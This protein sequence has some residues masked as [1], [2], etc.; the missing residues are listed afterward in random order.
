MSDTPPSLVRTTARISIRPIRPSKNRKNDATSNNNKKFCTSNISSPL[1]KEPFKKGWKREVVYRA[2]VDEQWRNKCDIYYFSPDGKKL[3][4]MPEISKYLNQSNSCFSIKNFSFFKEPIGMDDDNQEICRYAGTKSIWHGKQ[5]QNGLKKKEIVCVKKNIPKHSPRE[6]EDIVEIRTTNNT[7]T[8]KRKRS[9]DDEK[10]VE[11]QSKRR[12]S[13]RKKPQGKMQPHPISALKATSMKQPPTLPATSSDSMQLIL[14]R[15]DDKSS[16][17]CSVHD[18]SDEDQEKVESLQVQQNKTSL[19]KKKQN[20][21]PVLRATTMEEPPTLHA[22]SSDNMPVLRRIDEESSLACSVHDSSDED[23]EKVESPQGKKQQDPTF[24]AASCD[25]IPLLKRFDELSPACSVYDSSE[26]DQVN[27]ESLRGRQT[28]TRGK[29][30]HDPNPVVKATSMKQPPT[31]CAT[32]SDSLPLLRRF[33]DLSSQS[34]VHDSSDEDQEQVKSLPRHHTKSRGKKRQDRASKATSLNMPLL[35][36][37]DEESSP[38]CSVQDCEDKTVSSDEDQEKVESPVQEPAPVISRLPDAAMPFPET[39]PLNS[40]LIAL[41][42]VGTTL[43]LTDPST[44]RIIPPPTALTSTK[45][46]EVPHPKPILSQPSSDKNSVADS[47]KTS[48]RKPKATKKIQWATLPSSPPVN[49]RKLRSKKKPATATV[50]VPKSTPSVDEFAI[51]QSPSVYL[52]QRSLHEYGAVGNQKPSY[53]QSIGDALIEEGLKKAYHSSAK[54]GDNS[55]SAT[56]ISQMVTG[57]TK[58]ATPQVLTC[59]DFFALRKQKRKEQ[60][61]PQITDLDITSISAV[62][63]SNQYSTG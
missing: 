23:Q 18:C 33:C 24:P 62:E 31:L 53:W 20:P 4:S 26:E 40:P 22:T 14:T 48:F 63:K 34:S 27:V 30:Q 51:P 19:G 37:L 5:S 42:P 61:K 59:K 60:Q 1:L 9:C 38:S 43:V 3:R 45:E 7:L 12:V 35:T 11:N 8:K 50:S 17:A 28:R 44:L 32:S 39:L 16:P 57:A 15:V 47:S 54:I 56:P 21:I 58:A 2:I 36:R 13:T 46:T 6:E 55:I 41:L 25:K 52:N 10:D 49:K 29:K